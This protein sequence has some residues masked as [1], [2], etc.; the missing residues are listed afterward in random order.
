M[1]VRE[2]RQDK[3]RQWR[4]PHWKEHR[5]GKQMGDWTW[6]KPYRLFPGGLPAISKQCHHHD[7][8]LLSS[9]WWFQGANNKPTVKFCGRHL[10]RG[11]HPTDRG[12]VHNTLVEIHPLQCNYCS[13]MTHV[14]EYR[15]TSQHIL[16]EQ[17]IIIINY[18][19]EPS[20]RITLCNFYSRS[21]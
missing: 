16:R 12:S 18:Y 5:G 3:Y 15:I 2:C 8:H 17:I 7:R 9:S 11:Q 20:C 1:A 6:K 19:Y 21:L 14:D 13:P 10:H 4:L